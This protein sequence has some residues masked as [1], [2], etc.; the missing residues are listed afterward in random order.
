MEICLYLI[1]AIPE[2]CEYMAEHG[3]LTDD[4]IDRIL[5]KNGLDM[6]QFHVRAEDETAIE[7]QV[8]N[9]QR[10]LWLS[11]EG[12]LKEQKEKKLKKAAEEAAAA[13]AK[14]AA[15]KE[16]EDKKKQK[17][18]EKARKMAAKAEKQL[19]KEQA[20]LEKSSEAAASQV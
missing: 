16:K 12:F 14:E 2:M 20:K 17:E 7:D 9:R 6:E 15:R 4:E 10:V 5:E 19:Q 13:Q 11:N 18:E 1:R 3:R 8:L